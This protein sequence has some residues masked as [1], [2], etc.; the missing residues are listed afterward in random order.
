MATTQLPPGIYHIAVA[1]ASGSTPELLTRESEGRVTILHA[2]AQPD[3]E[4][5][6]I[7]RFLTSSIFCRSPAL[8]VE[9]HPW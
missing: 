1:R 8:L 3:P 2:S 5:E 7:S 4:Q 6:V 9:N